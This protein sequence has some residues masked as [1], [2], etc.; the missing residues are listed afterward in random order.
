LCDFGAKHPIALDEDGDGVKSFC[1]C[2]SKFCSV[3]NFGAKKLATLKNAPVAARQLANKRG[4]EQ[5][6]FFE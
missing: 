4:P 3:T 6:R 2:C 1:R 5:E